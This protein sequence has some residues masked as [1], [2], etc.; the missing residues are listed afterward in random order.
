MNYRYEEVAD[1]VRRYQ[2]I[3]EI[4]DE[5]IKDLENLQEVID[6]MSREENGPWF[7]WAESARKI[8]TSHEK[9]V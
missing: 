4:R 2:E 7:R 6:K 1:L 3:P 8:L 5:I 9:T